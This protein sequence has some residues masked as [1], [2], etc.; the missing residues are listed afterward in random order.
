MT[1]RFV[2]FRYEM[3]L[4]PAVDSND[5]KL[6]IQSKADELF[7][8]GWAQDT[9]R[10][11]VVGEARCTR[12]AGFQMKAHLSIL[13][14]DSSMLSGNETLAVRDYPDTLIRLHFSHFKLL[15][16]ERSTC[17][18]DEPHKCTQFYDQTEDG[19]KFRDR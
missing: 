14:S 4:A 15:S 9:H 3:K 12:D 16:K 19:V 5:I 13:S 17:F 8:F 7:C 11:T 10:Q 6:S 1:D 18:R 2:G